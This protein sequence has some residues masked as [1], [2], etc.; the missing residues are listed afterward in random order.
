MITMTNV[1]TA[2]KRSVQLD[3]LRGAA[4]LL[5]I[6]RHLEVPRPDGAVGFLAGLWHRIGW[7]GVDLFFVLSGFLIGGLL[8][9]EL[10]KHG[11]IHIPLFLI[12]RGLKIYPPYFVFIGYL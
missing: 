3:I 6:G 2:S 1:R 9:S 12:R 4:I 7:L 10:T 8:V 11:R 5:V